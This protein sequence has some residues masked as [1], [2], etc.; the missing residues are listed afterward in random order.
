MMPRVKVTTICVNDID[1]SLRFYC[2]GLGFITE[3]IIGKKF[4]S[5]DRT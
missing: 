1:K 5:R 2:Q 4:E 3:G